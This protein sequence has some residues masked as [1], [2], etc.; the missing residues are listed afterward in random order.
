MEKIVTVDIKKIK[1]KKLY[2]PRKKKGVKFS[3][4]MGRT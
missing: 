3:R 1:E 4:S 2:D